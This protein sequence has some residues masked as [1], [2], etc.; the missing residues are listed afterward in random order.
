MDN[1]ASF[2]FFNLKGEPMEMSLTK[3]NF[4]GTVEA[5]SGGGMAFRIKEVVDAINCQSQTE[6]DALKGRYPGLGIGPFVQQK[7]LDMIRGGIITESDEIPSEYRQ[8]L[9][10]YLG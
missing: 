2:K 8:Q 4:H 6:I 9:S 5:V 7:L 3:G 10:Q 1:N